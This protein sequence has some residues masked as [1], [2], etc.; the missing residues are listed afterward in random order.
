MYSIKKIVSTILVFSF[1]FVLFS[2]HTFA[3]ENSEPIDNT[4]TAENTLE[5]TAPT[6]NTEV[7]TNIK[8]KQPIE[9]NQLLEKEITKIENS[10][11]IQP[12]GLVGGGVLT[13]IPHTGYAEI[14]TDLVALE[15]ISVAYLTYT[16]YKYRSDGTKYVFKTVKKTFHPNG[17]R[18]IYDEFN[19]SLTKG[20]YQAKCTGTMYG[21]S[22]I[23]LTV[24]TFWSKKFTVN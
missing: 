13:A 2:Q 15:P 1:I 23:P 14:G 5:N 21:Y 17:S 11:D 19:Q 16:F 20:S 6:E 22:D 10:N 8:N 9:E 12:L 3:A 18:A 24:S 4:V 7:L